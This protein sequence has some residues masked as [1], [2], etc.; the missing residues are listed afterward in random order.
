MGAQ[1]RVVQNGMVPRTHQSLTTTFQRSLTAPFERGGLVV[2]H[3]YANICF[4]ALSIISF[5]FNG[6]TPNSYCHKVNSKLPKAYESR[7]WHVF[8]Q[9]HAMRMAHENRHICVRVHAAV[10][11]TTDATRTRQDLSRKSPAG[12][13]CLTDGCSQSPQ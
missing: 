9:C 4:I 6:S 11:Q 10:E 12:F 13:R 8:E 2:L 5:S 7:S 1:C 3:A